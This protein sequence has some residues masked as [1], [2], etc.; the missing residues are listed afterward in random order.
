[1][2]GL[3][4]PRANVG[5]GCAAASGQGGGGKEIDACECPEKHVLTTELLHWQSHLIPFVLVVFNSVLEAAVAY[6]LLPRVVLPLVPPR[7]ISVIR[8]ASALPSYTG[9]DYH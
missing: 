9:S 5:V 2:R 3:G 6:A 7:T 1:M 8:N 4:A